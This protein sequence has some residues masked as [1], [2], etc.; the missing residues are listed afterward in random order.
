MDAAVCDIDPFSH[1][2]FEEPHRIHEQLREA[3][4]VVWLPRWSTYAVA[5]Y[6]EVHAVL[7]DHTTFCS[8]RGVGLADFA[9]DKPWRPPSLILEADP[10]N[11]TKTRTVLNK[12]L[13]PG[14]TKTLRA[15]FALAADRLVDTLLERGTIDAIPD[16]TE[17]FPLSVFPDAVGLKNEGREHLLPYA[18]LAFNAFGPDNELRRKALFD[19]APHIEWVMEQC[20]RVN[21]LDDGFGAEIHAAADRGEITHQEAPLL[22]RSL[23]TAGID[24]TVNGIGAAVHCLARFP[25][26]WQR[27]REDPSLA[28]AAFE[29]AI[30]FEGGSARPAARRAIHPMVVGAR[31]GTRSLRGERGPARA[32][33]SFTPARRF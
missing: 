4:P 9:K 17:A 12:V 13:S 24:T 14:V 11:H 1:E 22:V 18:S 21:L 32:A 3:G 8:G 31:D 15:R 10:P 20:Q 33:L 19:A 16:L 28:K 7:E 29:E 27:L 25:D 5:R 2:F 30:R 6:A 23:L 26:Q